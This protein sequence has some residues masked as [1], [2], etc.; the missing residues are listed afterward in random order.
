MKKTT[1]ACIALLLMSVQINAQSGLKIPKLSTAIN[2]LIS[3][4]KLDVLQT[5]KIRDIFT[6][7]YSDA[8]QLK[9]KLVTASN[10]QK[11]KAY[12]E[13]ITKTD[14]KIKGVLKG[15]QVTEFA[16]WRTNWTNSFK[17]ANPKAS[18]IKQLENDLLL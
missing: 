12:S 7:S 5:G 2:Q 6:S 10:D 18:E 15:K 17:A 3:V 8:N 13:L 16:N 9:A 4:L 11:K 14:D 1:I